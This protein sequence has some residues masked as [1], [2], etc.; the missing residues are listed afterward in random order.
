MTYENAKNDQQYGIQ[1]TGSHKP[2]G[3]SLLVANI[4]IAPASESMKTSDGKLIKNNYIGNNF[5]LS[6]NY[7]SLNN[8]YQFNIPYNLNGAFLNT[9]QNHI[10]AS[11]KLKEWTFTTGMYWIGT[12]SDYKTKSL[13]ESLVNYS[14]RSQIF[15]NKSML[16][17][18]FSYDFSK[19]K[20]TIRIEN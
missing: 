11:Y 2:F 15:N 12:P 7:K 5:V 4:V 18:D 1:F 17:L 9:N 16:V 8:Q 13:P 19:G 20:K 3:N 10:F 6:C 14:R